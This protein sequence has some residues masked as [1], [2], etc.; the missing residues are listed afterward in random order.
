VPYLL[1][2]V[3]WTN[4]VGPH[5]IFTD[6]FWDWREHWE[7]LGPGT[8]PYSPHIWE[9]ARPPVNPRAVL[10]TPDQWEHGIDYDQYIKG[11]YPGSSWPACFPITRVKLDQIQHLFDAGYNHVSFDQIQGI[12]AAPVTPISLDQKQTLQAGV[13]AQISQKQ[14]LPA[15]FIP[16]PMLEQFQ[17]ISAPGAFGAKINQKQTISAYPLAPLFQK[18]GVSAPV[19]APLILQ[20]QGINASEG[21]GAELNQLQRIEAFTSG[22]QLEQKQTIAVAPNTPMYQKQTVAVSGTLYAPAFNISI[23][24]GQSIAKMGT[25]TISW[26]G[27]VAATQNMY[28]A[29]FSTAG[30][31]FSVPTTGWVAGA[32]NGTLA[33][34]YL[35]NAGASGSVQLKN[36]QPS[37]VSY[38]WALFGWADALSTYLHDTGVQGNGTLAGTSPATWSWPSITLGHTNDAL[39]GACV[40][41]ASV[42]GSWAGSSYLGI[43]QSFYT[44]DEGMSFAGFRGPSGAVTPSGSVST[45]AGGT[46][47]CILDAFK[48]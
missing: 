26:S 38:Y 40:V 6:R 11:A 9:G 43:W 10:G 27:G 21:F 20:K 8:V 41:N 45:G 37:A 44:G 14:K 12:S 23:A 39:C 2:A 17:S 46:Y 18:Q 29:V 22:G 1:Y 19:L 15:P 33:G 13:P 4:P 24:G 3:P 35:L 25:A 7:P 36:G 30:T 47:Q 28:L 31:V 48:P 16:L 42:G 5:T 32:S 34:F